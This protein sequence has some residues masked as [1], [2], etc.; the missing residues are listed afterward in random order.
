MANTTKLHCSIHQ[1]LLNK[2][3]PAKAAFGWEPVET[4]GPELFRL[5]TQEGRPFTSV[6][7]DN[8]RNDANWQKTSVIGLDFDG[9]DEKQLPYYKLEEDPFIKNHALFIYPS[10]S[11]SGDKQKYRVV[12]GVQTPVTQPEQFKALVSGLMKRMNGADQQCKDLARFFWGC[13]ISKAVK[14]MYFDNMLDEDAIAEISNKEAQTVDSQQANTSDYK[15]VDFF[16]GQMAEGEGRN[17]TVYDFAKDLAKSPLSL[18]SASGLVVSLNAQ[19]KQPLGLSELTV[20]FTNGWS[21]IRK[22][23]GDEI[24]VTFEDAYTAMCSP[25]KVAG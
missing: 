7:K 5:V 3:N 8:H 23:S 25:V 22:D 19:Q 6:F 18:A 4:A 1:Q 21:K 12:F 2:D 13:N 20:A 15:Y 24:D 16:S 10:P 17:A 9:T 14:P 11:W